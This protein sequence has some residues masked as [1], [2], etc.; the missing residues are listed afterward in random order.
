MATDLPLLVA[1]LR[2]GYSFQ[3]KTVCSVGAGGGQLLE[4]YRDAAAI[5]AVDIDAEALRRLEGA[6]GA[7]GLRDRAQLFRLDFLEYRHPAEVVVFEFSLHEMADPGCALRHA[8]T[9]APDI[10]VFD[11]HPQ[12][13]WAWQVCEED[14]ARRSLAALEAEEDKARR[15]LAALE[16]F[17]IRSRRDFRGLQVFAGRSDLEDRVRPQGEDAL[18]RAAVFPAAGPIRIP[19]DYYLALAGN[20]R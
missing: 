7:G 2:G 17:G 15:S 5:A 10:V 9:L 19:M 11:H 14:K 6:L 3:D 13:P 18:R 16:A 8:R 1:T 20:G 12:S 4:V